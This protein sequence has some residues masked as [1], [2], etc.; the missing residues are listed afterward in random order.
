MNCPN[1]HLTGADCCKVIVT[2]I[3]ISGAEEV[4]LLD[5]AN[6]LHMYIEPLPAGSPTK[7]EFEN[8]LVGQ[9]IPSN[10]IPAIEKGFKEAAN[11]GALIGHP[12]ENL[13][14][15]LTDGAAHAVD[16]SELAF[17]LASIYAFRQCYAASRPVILEPVMLV[18]LK[19]PTEFQGAVAG[20]INKRKGVIVG[21]DQEGDDSVITAHVIAIQPRLINVWFRRFLMA[22]DDPRVV[23]WR[24]WRRHNGMALTSAIRHGRLACLWRGSAISTMAAVM[25]VT[26]WRVMAAVADMAPKWA[27]PPFFL[28]W[29]WVKPT[30]LSAKQRH[31]PPPMSFVDAA[32]SDATTSDC[33]SPDATT[34]GAIAPS[35]L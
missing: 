12:V 20:D 25:E 19:V 5:V 14:V 21:N 22:L 29:A 33:D 28:V 26:A 3:V 17:K 9:A 31:P 10:F 30:R 7:F 13:R 8:M 23:K 11:S 16:S 18:E 34:S 2:T 6:D 24:L 15:V 4:H 32:A 35:R 27:F 1:I